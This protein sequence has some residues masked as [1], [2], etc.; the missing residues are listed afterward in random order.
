MDKQLNLKDVQKE[1]GLITNALKAGTGR[2]GDFLATS[3][4]AKR[5]LLEI[6]KILQGHLGIGYRNLS[7]LESVSSGKLQDARQIA[8]SQIDKIK[9]LLSDVHSA[10]DYCRHIKK[11]TASP[12]K[13]TETGDYKEI[14]KD[15]DPMSTSNVTSQ[16]IALLDAQRYGATT[17][18]ETIIK[19]PKPDLGLPTNQRNCDIAEKIRMG[20]KGSG[21]SGHAHHQ[22][23]MP[24]FYH[25]FCRGT[26]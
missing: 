15:P 4:K 1:I 23:T 13:T 9:K 6:E 18:H 22:V 19:Y 17:G 26:V 14:E 20:L 7:D 3:E 5:R 21:A 12:T 10:L 11:E 25:I 2:S 24:K 8:G 16:T